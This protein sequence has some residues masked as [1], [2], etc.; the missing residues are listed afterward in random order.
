VDGCGWVVLG[1]VCGLNGCLSGGE[2]LTS[3]HLG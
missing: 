2:D 1:Y 3:D